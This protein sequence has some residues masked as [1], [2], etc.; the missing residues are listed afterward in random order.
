MP[1]TGFV[2]IRLVLFTTA[3]NSSAVMTHESISPRSCSSSSVEIVTSPSVTTY[4][5][6]NGGATFGAVPERR[7]EGSTQMFSVLVAS[8]PWSRRPQTSW[9]RGAEFAVATSIRVICVMLLSSSRRCS[10]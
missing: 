6:L 5:F 9:G 8:S 10:E 2:A 7:C 3:R 1:F 4:A